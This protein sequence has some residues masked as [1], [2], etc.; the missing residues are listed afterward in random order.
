MGMFLLILQKIPV[1]LSLIVQQIQKVVFWPKLPKCLA[2][3][4]F[5][6]LI[7]TFS[8]YFIY[9]IFFNFFSRKLLGDMVALHTDRRTDG[10]TYIHGG[11]NNICLPQGET[12]NERFMFYYSE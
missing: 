11:K 12:Y 3:L 10:R 8:R 9:G 4:N 7:L 5:D 1:S 6:F 2:K